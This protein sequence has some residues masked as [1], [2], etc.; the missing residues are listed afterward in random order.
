MVVQRRVKKQHSF[1]K[2]VAVALLVLCI[3][4]LLIVAVGSLAMQ[5]F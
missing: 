5:F 2:I 1:L 4:V 3:V